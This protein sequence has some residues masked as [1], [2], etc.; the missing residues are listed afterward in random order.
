M[1]CNEI[2]KNIRCTIS[3]QAKRNWVLLRAAIGGAQGGAVN[4][5]ISV[6]SRG[7]GN[8][9]GARAYPL[10]RTYA[11]PT[12]C[13]FAACFYSIAAIGSGDAPPADDTSQ[14]ISS[15]NDASRSATPAAP[16]VYVV[17]SSNT[18]RSFDVNGNSLQQ[19]QFNSALGYLNGGMTL[20]MGLVY[21]TWAKPDG[22]GGGVFAFDARTLRQVR[23]HLS[24]FTVDAASGPGTLQ[25]IAFDAHQNRFYV[26]TQRLGLLAFNSFGV[27][28]PR[29]PQSTSSV[30]AVAYD[31]SQHSLWAIVDRHAVAQFSEESGTSLPGIPAKGA[32]YRHARG[33]LA[34]AYC[35]A[36]DGGS[37]PNAI[38]VAFGGTEAGSDAAGAGQSYDAAGK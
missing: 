18:L 5:M 13:A 22:A 16:A 30:A 7:L 17:D 33:P 38:A 32:P 6:D 10:L 36:S 28:I 25:G 14:A 4:S 12:A 35:A 1:P 23:L 9:S 31:S 24:A 19:R 37:A 29:D 34:V 26:A 8:E 3:G 2:V 20:A 11:L 27:Y 15:T 21:A